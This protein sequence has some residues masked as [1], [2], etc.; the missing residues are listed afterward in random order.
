[1]AKIPVKAWHHNI[2]GSMS[3]ASVYIL[4]SEAKHMLY[5]I[6]VRNAMPG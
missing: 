1:M 6:G 3:F 4:V 2:Q 5:G